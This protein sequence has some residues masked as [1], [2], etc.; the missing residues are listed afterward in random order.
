MNLPGSFVQVLHGL[1]SLQV[2]RPFTA[3]PHPRTVLQSA[4]SPFQP[5][6]DVR[7]VLLQPRLHA[8]RVPLA[9][10]DPPAIIF[11]AGI[12]SPH[13][14]RLYNGARA[15]RLPPPI[16]GNP[17]RQ[18]VGRLRVRFTP[19]RCANY[20]RQFGSPQSGRESIKVGPPAGRRRSRVRSG[21]TKSILPTPRFQ[22]SNL[23]QSLK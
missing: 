2:V 8:Q 14:I 9:D 7:R 3:A 5:P 12:P 20:I 23:Q 15:M 1:T 16:D 22:P 19:Q 4:Q 18:T 10:S 17:R 13:C 6:P 21:C 11:T